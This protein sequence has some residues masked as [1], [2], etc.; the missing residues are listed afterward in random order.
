M[1]KEFNNYKD[2]ELYAATPPLE[3]LRLIISIAASRRSKNGRRWKIMVNDVSRA[4]FYAESMKPTF[5]QICDED[6]G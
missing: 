2:P 1:A 3:L 6:C 5:V 4:Y